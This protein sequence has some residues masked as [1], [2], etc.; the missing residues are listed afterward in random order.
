MKHEARP[1]LGAWT[2]DV[3]DSREVRHDSYC[4]S[5]SS[6]PLYLPELNTFPGPSNSQTAPMSAYVVTVGDCWSHRALRASVRRAFGNALRVE[7]ALYDES[8]RDEPAFFV[9]PP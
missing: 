9:S 7:K 6:L 5:P 2:Q 4:D 3:H 1:N 8:L